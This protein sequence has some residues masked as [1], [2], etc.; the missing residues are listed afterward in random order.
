MHKSG[1]EER[2]GRV[3]WVEMIVRAI[4]DRTIAARV[5]GEVSKML[6][7]PAMMYRL[8]MVQ[9]AEHKMLGFSE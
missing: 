8:E 4:C 2:A 1:Q 6:V 9:K 3:E 5:K 7:R